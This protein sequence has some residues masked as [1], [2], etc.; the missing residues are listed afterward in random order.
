MYMD[1]IAGTKN[2]PELRIPIKLIWDQDIDPH[3]R[4]VGQE[5]HWSGKVRCPKNRSVNAPYLIFGVFVN[6]V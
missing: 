6:A 3:W 5:E 4:D 1:T 2:C